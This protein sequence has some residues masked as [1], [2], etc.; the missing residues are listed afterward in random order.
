MPIVGFTVFRRFAALALAVGLLAPPALAAPATEQTFTFTTGSA[1][2][3]DNGRRAVDE[4]ATQ[5]LTDVDARVVIEGHADTSGN[6]D[7]NAQFARKRAERVAERLKQRG[8][9]ADRITVESFGSSKPATSNDTAEGRALNRRVVIRVDAPAAPV[10]VIVPVVV[11]TPVAPAPEP[12][13][14]V[15]APPVV[16]ADPTP[17]AEVVVAETPMPVVETEAAWPKWIAVVPAIVGVAAAAGSIA[18][19]IDADGTGQRL[20]ISEDQLARSDLR[21]EVRTATESRHT[22]LNDAFVVDMGLG[23]GLGVVAVAGIATA[24]VLVANGE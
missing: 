20:A 21:P 18:F 4:L 3:D 19:F 14:V 16:E 13:V 2:L 24:I 11:E 6:A 12:V 8:V 17:V 9:A 10:A 5:L 1:D 15:E 7:K 22:A 23:I